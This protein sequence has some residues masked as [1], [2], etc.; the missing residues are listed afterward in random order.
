MFSLRWLGLIALAGV[1]IA[2]CIYLG[3][4]Q[5]Q[6][7]EQ[8]AAINERIAAAEADDSPAPVETLLTVDTQPDDGTVWTKVRATGT[9]DTEG[10]ILIRARSVNSQAGYEVVTPLLLADGTAVLVD[11]GWIPSSPS[12]ATELPDVPAAPDGEVEI[13]GRVRASES[14]IADINEVD[15]ARQARSVNVDQ[16]ADDLDYPVLGGYITDDDP[17]AGFTEIP[18]VEQRSW[19]N[20]A[21][22]YQWWLFALLIPV[23]LV[24]IAR[25]EANTPARA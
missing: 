12:G 25:R 8:R 4:W 2:A 21:Y 10:Q 24:M 22:A 1:L 13:T 6:R 15:G 18:V 16:I 23:G 9:F 14:R 19:Q 7:Y 17:A 3:D 11:R 20:F 5:H